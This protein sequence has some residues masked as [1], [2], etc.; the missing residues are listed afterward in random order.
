MNET[1]AP[2][3]CT[4]I[5]TSRHCKAAGNVRTDEYRRC[6]KNTA[7]APGQD[8]I[9]IHCIKHLMLCLYSAIPSIICTLFLI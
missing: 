8:L 3:P 7:I 4:F 1:A 9:E 6:R 2:A 5:S